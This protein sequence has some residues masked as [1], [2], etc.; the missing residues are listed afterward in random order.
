MIAA[1]LSL[2]SICFNN[3][4]M[5]RIDGDCFKRHGGDEAHHSEGLVQPRLRYVQGMLCDSGHVIHYSPCNCLDFL[6][7]HVH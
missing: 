4:D 6:L 3:S 7:H 1:I 2:L 5:K